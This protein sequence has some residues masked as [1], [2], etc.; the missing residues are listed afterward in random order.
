MTPFGEMSTNNPIETTDSSFNLNKNTLSTSETEITSLNTTEP[1]T[2]QSNDVITAN[3]ISNPLINNKNTIPA[4]EV[5]PIASNL[6][7]TLATT[8][9]LIEN[10]LEDGA[11]TTIVPVTQN[12]STYYK[13]IS[14]TK[15]FPIPSLETTPYPEVKQTKSILTTMP[16]TTI[17][18]AELSTL[19]PYTKKFTPE[20]QNKG[21]FLK[22]SQSQEDTSIIENDTEAHT[23]SFKISIQ[24]TLAENMFP[25]ESYQENSSSTYSTIGI[26]DYTTNEPRTLKTQQSYAETKY[27]TYSTESDNEYTT[28]LPRTTSHIFAFRTTTNRQAFTLTENKNLLHINNGATTESMLTTQYYLQRNRVKKSINKR[29][30]FELPLSGLGF[31]I[32]S[33]LDYFDVNYGTPH[34]FYGYYKPSSLPR[35]ISTYDQNSDEIEKLFYV[36]AYEPIHVTYKIYNN[37]LRFTYIESIH[38]SVLELPLNSENYV[39]MLIIP[40]QPFGLDK[41]MQDMTSSFAPSIRE[42]RSNLKQQWMKATV[43]KFYLHGSIVFTTD[44]MKVSTF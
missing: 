23:E 9:L 2:Q 20:Y 33:S 10:R 5:S 24:T 32:P 30:S 11:A 43:P 25:F 35:K 42:I 37:I 17:G 22:S 31:A 44:L 6:A 13:N 38:S 36:N 8:L 26:N 19:N 28:N 1:Q 29:S 41:L 3:T 27:S 39:L 34:P 21:T 12:N 16:D 4:T 18:K 15:D 14:A 7:T 40:D